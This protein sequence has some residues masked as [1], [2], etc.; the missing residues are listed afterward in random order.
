MAE[1]KTTTKKIRVTLVRSAIGYNSDQKRTI[2]AL[3]LN[4]INSSKEIVD[5]PCTRG[6]I[7]KVRHLVSIEEIN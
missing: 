7:N 1:K 5:N 2:E 6:M 4:K 3:G